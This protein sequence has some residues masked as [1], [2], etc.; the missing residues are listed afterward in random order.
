MFYVLEEIFGFSSYYF[1][2]Y[3]MAYGHE[4]DYRKSS[5]INLMDYSRVL[6]HKQDFKSI[7]AFGLFESSHIPDPDICFSDDIGHEYY[8]LIWG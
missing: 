8:M 7:Y 5:R 1:I 6:K 3:M 2:L 4:C